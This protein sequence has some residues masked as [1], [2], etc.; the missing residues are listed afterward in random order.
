MLSTR[1][2]FS[3]TSEA[4]RH[5]LDKLDATGRFHAMF[6]VST[7]RIFM[8]GEA[9]ISTFLELLQRAKFKG[10]VS[11]IVRGKRFWADAAYVRANRWNVPTII[12]AD[13]TLLKPIKAW[14]FGS[15]L[16]RIWD[17]TGTLWW[18]AALED[19]PTGKGFKQL[20]NSLDHSTGPLLSQRFDR[21]TSKPF[22]APS[23]EHTRIACPDAT[24]RW[25]VQLQD[26]SALAVGPLSVPVISGNGQWL[27]AFDFYR[28][29]VRIYQLPEGTHVAELQ[30]DTSSCRKCSWLVS[31]STYRD[32]S[33]YMWAAL[34]Q[35]AWADTVLVTLHINTFIISFSRE[36]I[37][38]GK[39]YYVVGYYHPNWRI[40]R[41]GE[42]VL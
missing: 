2:K 20:L 30:G 28:Y 27:A 38:V 22:V 14:D 35:P 42:F 40:G 34:T 13:G 17:S 39:K 19:V 15:P 31:D 29:S 12:D 11:V 37:S 41:G 8:F 6:L 9:L 36:N 25:S 16:L 3:G 5:H 33:R 1:T 23:V 21:T 10:S 32:V 7:P 18:W 24:I 4:V 26:D